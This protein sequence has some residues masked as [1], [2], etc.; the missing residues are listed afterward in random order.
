MIHLAQTLLRRISFETTS[1]SGFTMIELLIVISILGILATA[2]LSA[3][4]P[5]EQINRGRDTGS[6]SDAEQLISASDRYY[7]FNGTYP[8][9]G[10]GEA[11]KNRNA[12]LS[13]QVLNN[14]TK[15][16]ATGNGSQDDYPFVLE[17]L[18]SSNELKASFISRVA[19]AA[20]PLYIYN[21]GTRGSSTYVCFAPASEAFYRDAATRCEGTSDTEG[22]MPSDIDDA[23]EALICGDA[24]GGNS[25][26]GGI[27]LVRQAYANGGQ[28]TPKEY[29]YCLP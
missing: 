4:N 17:E 11:A 20:N 1:R 6:M 23:T 16:T 28:D 5:I 7:A 10:L 22:G 26:D 15:A 27:I 8:W 3:I 18:L 13:F 14:D 9:Q 19:N 25:T 2:V 29:F 21:A 12:K 24:Q